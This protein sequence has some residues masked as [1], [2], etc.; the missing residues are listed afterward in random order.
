MSG[1]VVLLDTHVISEFIKKNPDP[2]V[3]QW[4]TTVERLA[5]SVV[6]LE[7]AHFGLTWQ[8]HARKLALF[9]G[10]V[11]NLHQV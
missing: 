4:L 2:Q 6:T 11:A 5:I 3:M 10:I 9:N 1:S 8:P 7:E